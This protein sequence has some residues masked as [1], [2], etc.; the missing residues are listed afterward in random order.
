MNL[1]MMVLI[2][3]GMT[4]FIGCTS[5]ETKNIEPPTKEV[6]SLPDSEP[7]I[8]P[9]KSQW[10][11]SSLL[12]INAQ[13][14]SDLE[15]LFVLHGGNAYL[16]TLAFNPS[17]SLLAS[18][19][20]DG[21]VRFWDMNSGD[22]IAAIKQGRQTME[23]TFNPD[24]TILASGDSDGAVRLWDMAGF[25]ELGIFEGHVWGIFDVDF[26]PDGKLIAS[27][28]VDQSVR[29][30]EVPDGPEKFI[31]HGHQE[32]VYAVDF[33]PDGSILASGSEDKSVRLWDVASGEQ[34]S[35]LSAH[36]EPVNDVHFNPDGSLLVTCG[37]GIAG[38]DNAVRIWDTT[39]WE[40]ILALEDHNKPVSGCIFNNDGGL[41]FTR[42]QGPLLNVWEMPSGVLI[43]SLSAFPT[44]PPSMALSPDGKLLVVGDPEGRIHVYGVRQ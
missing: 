11:L 31:L 1:K 38:R 6:L 25:K 2:I 8:S 3:A 37:G 22:E 34:I 20:I 43:K 18:G 36:Q 24:G 14:A 12:E 35:Q 30:W 23:I 15:E 7:T 16:T 26:S 40:V 21:D 10:E 39:D 29:V 33:S 28:S 19:D 32:D 44:F 42:S 13:S 4:L 27:G 5:S 41:L 17:G 9:S